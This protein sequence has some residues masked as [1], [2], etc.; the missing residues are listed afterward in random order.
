MSIIDVNQTIVD[1]LDLK[2]D[3]GQRFGRSLLPL[4]RRE[5]DAWG[6]VPDV[7]FYR[8]EWYNGKWYGIRAVRTPRWKYCWNPVGIDELYDLKNDAGETVNRIG[9]P[10]AAGELK[11]LQRRLIAHL[12]ETGDPAMKR[13]RTTWQ[14]NDE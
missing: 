14:L 1:W 6:G 4:I 9:D 5:K 10:K 11:R 2:P 13:F 8:Y 12:E 7:A 3:N